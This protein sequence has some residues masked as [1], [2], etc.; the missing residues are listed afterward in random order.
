M[1]LGHPLALKGADLCLLPSGG[2]YW[3]A[4]RLLCVSDLHL[5][6]SE[7]MARRAGILLPPYDTRATLDRLDA[8]LART[9]PAQVICLGDSF[10]DL[11]AAGALDEGDRLC[12]VRMMAGRDWIWIEGNHDPGPID[13]GG[14]HRAEARLGPLIFRHIAQSPADAGEVSGH[15]HPKARIGGLSRPCFMGDERRLI[16]PAYGSYTG[17]LDC[18]DP[19][20]AGLFTPE[21]R[22]IL[23]GPRAIVAPLA[24]IRPRA[25][26]LSR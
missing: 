3:P 2:V 13:L 22:V 12:L 25:S 7:R 15:F 16:L 17:G 18:A 26:S 8:D 9:D 23:T 11:A 6:R 5:G 4:R 19:A 24:Q 10:D 20:L 21:A 1:S 14:S